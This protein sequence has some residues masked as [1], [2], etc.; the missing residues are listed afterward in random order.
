MSDDAAPWSGTYRRY[1]IV[2]EFTV[3]F[4]VVLLLSVLLAFVFSSPDKAPVTVRSWADHTPRD[5]LATAVS[6]LEGTSNSATYGPPY[7]HQHSS[8]QY[9]FGVSIQQALGVH[10]PLDPKQAFVLEPLRTIPGDPA[11]AAALRRFA[12]APAAT[13]MR[14]E[15]T[16][17]LAIPRATVSRSGAVSVPVRHDGP[18]PTML[19]GLLG[20]ARSGALDTALDSNKGFY[21]TDYTKPIMFIGDSWKEFHDKSYWGEI[22]TAEHLAGDQWGVMNETGSWPGQPWLWL[23]TMWYQIPPMSTSSNGD[24]EVIAIMTVCT[25]ALL[26]VPFIPGLRDLPRYVP[27]Y[28]L[29]WREHY[30]SIAKAVPPRDAAPGP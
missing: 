24:V 11:L 30:R 10:V 29:I 26:A 19:S 27:I 7:N 1:D 17:A 2:R 6:E 15:E 18:V 13:Q 21:T 9:L 16:Y 28:R 4:V 3:A 25:L 8:V 22:V 5:F 12:A 23:Y 14:W 20:M